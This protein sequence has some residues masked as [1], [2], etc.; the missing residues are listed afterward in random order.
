MYRILGWHQ[1]SEPSIVHGSPLLRSKNCGYQMRGFSVTS[2]LVGLMRRLW[3]FLSATRHTKSINR[4]NRAGHYRDLEMSPQ[5]V[6]GYRSF[7]IQVILLRA[8]DV[9]FRPSLHSIMWISDAKRLALPFNSPPLFTYSPT[10]IPAVR[11][12][13]V[14]GNSH[15]NTIG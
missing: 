10:V 6:A 2:Q 13:Y 8:A 9:S 12:Y 15:G 7:H 14:L 5:A 11:P 4:S 3:G 1:Q